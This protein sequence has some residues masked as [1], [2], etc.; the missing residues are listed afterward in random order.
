MNNLPYFLNLNSICGFFGENR[1]LSNF[2]VCNEPRYYPDNLLS[3]VLATDDGLF[4]RNKLHFNIPDE[5]LNSI[6]SFTNSEAFYQFQKVN[7]IYMLSNDE[8]THT[9][10]M[11]VLKKFEECTP[12]ESK[13]LIK[14]YKFDAL[15]C[16]TWNKIKV[17]IMFDAVRYKFKDKELRQKLMDTG[18]SYLEE[19]LYWDDMFWGVQYNKVDT[20]TPKA[21]RAE[22][23]SFWEKDGGKNFLGRILMAIRQENNII[24]DGGNHV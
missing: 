6:M 9:P 12:A 1:F 15:E 21:I 5:E 23:G 3:Y 14:N 8:R 7:L 11:D 10:I 16:V 2:H 19:S 18:I 4:E 13:K 24:K 20:S 17:N 22:D